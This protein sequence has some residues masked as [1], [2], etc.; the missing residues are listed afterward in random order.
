MLKTPWAH[1]GDARFIDRSPQT[2]E[3]GSKAELN[4][5]TSARSLWERFQHG[6]MGQE[7]ALPMQPREQDVFHSMCTCLPVES[8]HPR[9]T[10]LFRIL[11]VSLPSGVTGAD[12]PR[13]GSGGSVQ[14][15]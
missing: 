15:P 4:K 8:P 13:A 11:A 5:A 12:T 1:Q 9:V 3:P 7:P 2:S 14:S 6:R 10:P